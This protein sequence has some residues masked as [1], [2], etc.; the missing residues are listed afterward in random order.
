MHYYSV[1]YITK[2]STLSPAVH[3]EIGSS[4]YEQIFLFGHTLRLNDKQIRYAL[5]SYLKDR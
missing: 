2:P 3:I 5:E 1:Y 4:E